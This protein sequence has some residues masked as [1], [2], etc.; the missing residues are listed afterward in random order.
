MLQIVPTRWF[1]WDFTVS[2]GSQPVAAIDMSCWRERG[3]L[4]VEGR[5]FR[6]SREGLLSGAFRLESGD[7]VVARA[8]KPSILRRSFV[9]RHGSK[10]YTLRPRSAWRRSF[11]LLDGDREV[12][13]IAPTSAWTR[14]ASA[15]LPADVPAPVQMFLIWLAV[16]LWKRESESVAAS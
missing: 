3:E 10:T 14:R 16:L 5:R 13:T 1:S 2:R 9:V 6:V 12:G 8:T 4:T 11:V 15:D 7:E